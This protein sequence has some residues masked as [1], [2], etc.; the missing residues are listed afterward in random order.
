MNR[1][2]KRYGYLG[3]PLV[4]ERQ[5]PW[6]RLVL[7]GLVLGAL[8]FAGW[9]WLTRPAALPSPAAAAPARQ[10]ASAQ[11]SL[12]TPAR[13]AAIIPT[14]TIS[15][16]ATL[17]PTATSDNLQDPVDVELSWAERGGRAEI[18][19][20]TVQAGDTLWSIAA[21]HNLD[22]DTL[23]WSNPELERNPDMLSVGTELVIL[24]VKGVYHTV[25]EGETLASIA[26]QFGV[27][28]ADILNYPLNQLSSP[29]R[30]LA[31]QKLVVPHGRKEVTRPIPQRS[32]DTLFAWPIVGTITQ[33]FSA[34]HPAFDIGA[35]YGS[36]VY[37]ARAGRV[38]RSAWARTGYGYTVIIDHGQSWQSLYS[39]MK[40]EW[41]SV[42]DWVE[43]G[44]LIGEVGSTGN[45]TGPHVH[46]E[47][48]LNGKQV[49]PVEYLPSGGPR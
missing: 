40:G 14:A 4:P 44:Q 33:G 24:P 29:D 31:G 3:Y 39:H 10:A 16:S 47:I 15:A 42:G 32:G 9:Q 36:P 23:R 6:P 13:S 19:T 1:P 43:Q 7:A 11:P 28:D 35:P 41:V 21:Q 18:V 49:N 45:S 17:A 34:Q 25:E 20:Y 2:R 46:F 26:K 8:A 48:R 5:H 38:V 37:A 22:V 27:S 12:G 30:L